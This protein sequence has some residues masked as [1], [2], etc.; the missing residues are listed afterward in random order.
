MIKRKKNIIFPIVTAVLICAIIAV[1]AC[2]FPYF[3]RMLLIS[4]HPLEYTE[5]VE[6]SAA[7]NGIDKYLVYAVIKTES[8][9]DPDAVSN[10]GARGLMQIMEPTFDWIK[11]RL[12][13]GDEITYENMFNPEIN[14]R[15]GCYLIGYLMRYYSEEDVAVC[16]Y[17]AGT[18]NVDGWLGNKEYSSDGV[19]LRK[20]PISDTAH[21]LEKVK[22]AKN[23]YIKLYKTEDSKNG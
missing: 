3:N 23:N 22:N 15:Y 13:D 20:I 7:E 5:Y 11:Y 8:G 21:Y 6:K 17:H 4:S 14:I 18:G 9:F 10:V 12:G 2:T 19:S 1:V 16:A